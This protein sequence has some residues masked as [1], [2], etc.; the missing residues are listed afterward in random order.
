MFSLHYKSVLLSLTLTFSPYSHAEQTVSPLEEIKQARVL[1]EKIQGNYAQQN[2]HD[3]QNVY[4]G[5]Q[6]IFMSNFAAKLEANMN[7]LL[8]LLRTFEE[9]KSE[10]IP[11]D[12]QWL[13]VSGNKMP[14]KTP[15]NVGDAN[16]SIAICR[17]LFLGSYL[18]NQGLYP[19]QITNG[20][21]RISYGGYA[22][23]V[24]T[25]DVLTGSN[26]QLKWIPITDIDKQIQS[27]NNQQKTLS[28]APTLGQTATV[29]LNDVY[30]Q[31][32]N[33]TFQAS[34]NTIKINGARPLS[35]G[36][37]GNNPVFICR[38]NQNNQHVIGK[39]V[40]FEAGGNNGIQHACD[41]GV[42]NKEIVIMHTYDVLFWK[43]T[44]G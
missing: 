5:N 17:G 28:P 26:S 29:S 33:A 44:A 43:G 7:E 35:G 22:F 16:A 6:Q 36:Y 14:T 25:F 15:V 40:F 41:I 32:Q 31:M 1:I 19:G 8:G 18:Q 38:A 27:E 21:C 39:L 30:Y 12:L 34:F 24:T 42:N 10:G 3:Q 9:I 20:G 11:N 37:E 4:L 2:L 23:I 13:A